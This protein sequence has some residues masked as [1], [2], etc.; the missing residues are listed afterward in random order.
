MFVYKNLFV[1]E[2]LLHR[3][4]EETPQSPAEHYSLCNQD[5]PHFTERVL[6]IHLLYNVK[7]TLSAVA[8]GTQCDSGALE[9]GDLLMTS[10][11]SKNISQHQRSLKD[12]A[13]KLSVK[14]K[15][16]MRLSQ[17]LSLP[18]ASFLANFFLLSK[19]LFHCITK[20]IFSRVLLSAA[21][22]VCCHS[23]PLSFPSGDITAL[24]Y[25]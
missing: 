12:E 14:E 13:M 23:L 3:C 15:W 17:I 8:A 19:I 18:F 1:Y 25:L 9:E 4:W 7:D 6:W 21:Q 2:P 5:W 22:L 11:D 16:S 24:Q 10:G 20:N